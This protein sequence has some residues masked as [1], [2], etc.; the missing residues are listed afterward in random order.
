VTGIARGRPGY[1]PFVLRW[2]PAIAIAALIFWLSGIP[3]LH[4]TTGW[5]DIVLRKGA[6][7][8]VYAALAVACLRGAR[9]ARIAFALA[10]AYAIT[11]EFH[12]TF[13]AGR[14]G[15][16]R[17]VLIDAVGAALGLLAVRRLPRVQRLVLA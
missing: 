17:D 12:Q 3:D 7:M 10:V 8:T 9:D 1:P 4:A 2:L 14:H 13:V 15:T 5:V 6:H 16:P 11:D